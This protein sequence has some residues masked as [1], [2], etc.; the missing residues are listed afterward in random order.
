M[1]QVKI[2]AKRGRK[3]GY[4]LPFEELIEISDDFTKASNKEKTVAVVNTLLALQR[5]YA[6][7]HERG[8]EMFHGA[9]IVKTKQGRWFLQA[10]MHLPN[11][12]TTR[13]CAESNAITEA[14]GVEGDKLEVS[15]IYFMGGMANFEQGQQFIRNEGQRNTPCGSC[16]DVIFN[17]RIKISG[18]TL[19]HMLPLN[20][21]TK[22]L[23]PGNPDDPRTESE[24]EPN[25][26]FTR[27]ISDL[28]PHLTKVI[29]GA[30]G[31]ISTMIQKSY[32]WLKDSHLTTAISSASLQGERIEA[33]ELES[34]SATSEDKLY[35]INR[36]LMNAAKEYYQ[37]SEVK[38]DRLSVAIVRSIDGHYFLA[39]HASSKT[40]IST[41]NETVKAINSMIS[42]SMNHKLSDVFVVEFDEKQLSKLA[43]SDDIML[44][45]PDGATREIIKKATP[46]NVAL[47]TAKG[48]DG[49]SLRDSG[50]KV[51]IFLPNDPSRD[52]FKPDQ[53]VYSYAIKELLPYG[54]NNPKSQHAVMR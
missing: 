39:R 6:L 16:L 2:H 11:A 36:A 31:A 23:L 8:G 24:L 29:N 20:D 33:S 47:M 18:D 28:L 38:P 50:A 32:E 4:R 1:P 44:K 27:R 42:A 3:T 14:R 41:P 49:R 34:D 15:D 51:H 22:K 43:E 30:G 21:G 9:A 53:H 7:D 40:L 25:R 10:N 48:F 52:D 26:I 45:L 13:N 35:A 17:N 54:Y 5:S 12:E 19:V 37:T 46:K